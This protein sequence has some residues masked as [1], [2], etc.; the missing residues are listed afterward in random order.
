MTRQLQRDQTN[1]LRT[2]TLDADQILRQAGKLA[3]QLAEMATRHHKL[4]PLAQ[5][6]VGCLA[7]ALGA[8][9]AAFYWRRAAD[10]TTRATLRCIATYARAA[11]SDQ[12]TEARLKVS[13]YRAI[14]SG[15]LVE[16]MRP[17]GDTLPADGAVREH[18][19]AVPIGIAMP[20]AVLVLQ[21]RE[22]AIHAHNE[23]ASVLARLGPSLASATRPAHV[24]DELAQAEHHH[25]PRRTIFAISSE[26]I[27]TMD[28]GFV[29]RELN[30]AASKLLGWSERAAI[31]QHCSKVLHCRDERRAPLC[32]T[33]RCPLQQA[34]DSEA[35][36]PIRDLTWETRTGK[37]CELSASITV[38]RSEEDIHAIVVARDVTL[39]NAANRLRANFISMVSHELRTPLNSINGFLEI[40]LDGP[41]G[42]LNERQREF[43]TYARVS[44]QQLTTLVEDILFISKADSGQFVLRQDRVAVPEL[45]EQLLQGLRTTAAHARVRIETAVEAGLPEIVADGLRLQ[46]VLNNLLNNAVKFS[47]PEATV[48][49]AVSRSDGELL[50]TVTDQGRGVPAEEHARIFERFYQ[51]DSPAHNRAGGYGLGLSIA[52]LIV[53]QHNGRIWVESQ[54]G[55]GATFA[56]SLPLVQPAGA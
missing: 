50:F 33:P 24:L 36:T 22:S 13:A 21:W 7:E 32:H 52:K 37:L 28:E 54:P 8:A 42:P 26:A 39:L 25:A 45:I 2:Q 17:L 4:R 46:Q 41:V 55:E 9:E 53:E 34:F 44:T 18:T 38:Q 12:P 6:L 11:T 40:V 47:P 20:W 16:R 48:R 27:L 51:S 30:P 5:E 49:L 23:R 3:L 43:L 31:G 19:V 14:S 35:A 1:A 10:P 29:I 15:R 56:F